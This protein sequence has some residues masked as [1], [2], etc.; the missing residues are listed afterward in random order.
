MFGVCFDSLSCCMMKV[1]GIKLDAF[2]CRLIDNAFVD[3]LGFNWQFTF[4]FATVDVFFSSHP[5]H[6][7]LMY[8]MLYASLISVLIDFYSIFPQ[9][10]NSQLFPQRQ[11]PG[12]HVGLS[13]FFPF[14]I[15][16]RGRPKSRSLE[17]FTGPQMFQCF[18]SLKMGGFNQK[19]L[20]LLEV[21]WGL[22]VQ[23]KIKIVL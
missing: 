20:T 11:L 9:L 4:S 8:R 16:Q 23:T 13:F 18:W 1:L 17:I 14:Q 7:K 5:G 6:S 21:N 10:Q 2:L 12:L 3:F 22:K 15:Q 19:L